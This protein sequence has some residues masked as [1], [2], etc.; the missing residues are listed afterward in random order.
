[1]PT[2]ASY[3]RGQRARDPHACKTARFRATSHR[4]IRR[5]RWRQR[6]PVTRGSSAHDVRSRVCTLQQPARARAPQRRRYARAK[7]AAISTR[8][9]TTRL[10]PR[11][12]ARVCVRAA[13]AKSAASSP[14]AI[15]AAQTLALACSSLVCK[16]R[17]L[18]DSHFTYLQ[19]L[20]SVCT[21]LFLLLSLLLL[22]AKKRDDRLL[23][24][25][26]FFAA[27]LL[28]LCC[29]RRRC[30]RATAPLV[31]TTISHRP[32]ARA[33]HSNAA[34]RQ[35]G[36]KNLRIVA[37]RCARNVSADVCSRS[38]QTTADCLRRRRATSLNCHLPT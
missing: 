19:R 23:A 2:E 4:Q 38:N 10:H 31:D 8:A 6:R 34:T 7:L 5:R 14:T 20:Q 16:M 18:F 25:P 33:S 1:M 35:G 17:V 21:L 12:R 28:L 36:K 30:R 22:Q 9:L 11:A 3:K 32:R 15:S 13:A 37:A 27:C 29:R 26:P 24:P